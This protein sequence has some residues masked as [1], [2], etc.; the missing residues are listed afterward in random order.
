MSETS[1][2][3]P[4]RYPVARTEYV[5]AT[6][7]LRQEHVRDALTELFPFC[8]VSCGDVNAN[9]TDITLT[10]NGKKYKFEVMNENKTSYIDENRAVRTLRNLDG[11][12]W[13]A[14]ICSHGNF[15]SEDAKGMFY[16]T[17]ILRL[18]WQELCPKHHDF[19]RKQGK[20]YR[21][22]SSSK[23]TFKLLKKQILLFLVKMKFPLLMY[24]HYSIIDSSNVIKKVH[25]SF[26]IKLASFS[27]KAPFS[28]L[29]V[30]LKDA[31][32]SSKSDSM[33]GNPEPIAVD[34]G[35]AKVKSDEYKGA[36]ISRESIAD[37]W[38]QIESGRVLPNVSAVRFPKDGFYKIVEDN[39]SKCPYGVNVAA[40]VEEMKKSKGFF[41]QG[42]PSEY[43]IVFMEDN[44]EAETQV[45]MREL[46]KI[47]WKDWA[48]NNSDC[49]RQ[50]VD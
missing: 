18:G 29:K 3:I 25:C 44:P 37:L 8:Q 19:Y 2:E 5:R 9:G 1:L 46:V 11:A 45:L 38:N 15:N 10:Y 42:A 20:V 7:K 30:R 12:E 28:K 21:R 6:G 24:I 50:Y 22:K 40:K 23:K 27:G 14:F 47:A 49:W 13:S 4:F 31:V 32:F 35:S 48:Q 33:S 39:A 41:L 17:P 36:P 26:K 34:N 43:C 16:G